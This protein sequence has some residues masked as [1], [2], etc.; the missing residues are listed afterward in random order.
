MT[1]STKYRKGIAAFLFT[2]L[3]AQT[4]LPVTALALTSGPAQ[5]ESSLFQP[6]GVSDMVDMFTGDFNYN[7]PVLDID[8]YPI[9]LS[10]QSG[11]GMDDEASWV[12][13]GWGLNVGA[14]TRQ[15]R[16]IPDDLSGSAYETE[17]YTKPKVTIGGRLTGKIEL[18]GMPK[19]LNVGGSLS[20]GVFSDNYTGIGAELGANAGISYTFAGSGL[21]TAGMGLGIT[22]STASGVDVS[23]SLSLAY[24]QKVSDNTT[25]SPGLSA[26]LG[27]NTRGGLKDLSLG[28]T[29]SGKSKK[30]HSSNTYDVAGATIFYNTDPV[31]PKVQIPYKSYNGSFSFD[32][33]GAGWLIFAGG[34]GTGY[35]TVREVKSQKMRNPAFGFLYAE[36]GKKRAEALMDFVREKENAIIPEIPNLAIPVATP[37]LF[38]YT[39]Q[40]GSGQ[41][42][43]Y[44]GGTGILFDNE[45]ADEDESQSVGFDAGLGGIAHGGVTLYNQNVTNTTS[46]WRDQNNFLPK[47]DFQDALSAD[48]QAEHAFFKQVGEKTQ[49]DEQMVKRLEGTEP[50][51]VDITGKTANNKWRKGSQLVTI[52]GS[53]IKDQKEKKR[54]VISYLTASEAHR[55]GL[56]KIIK[57]YDPITYD[58]NVPFQPT[59]CSPVTNKFLYREY[60]SLLPL[61][62]YRDKS[63]ISELTVTDEAGSRSVYG[64]P[65]YNAYQH[66]YSYALGKKGSQTY[67]QNTAQGDIDN[68]L[69][70]VVSNG[71]KPKQDTE[72]ESDNYLHVDKQPGYA[73]SFLLS[74]ILSPDYVDVTGNG[75]TDDDQGTAIK[76]NYSMLETLYQWRTPFG[77][78][79]VNKATINK[80]MMADPDDDKAS[81]VHGAKELW[82]LHSIETKTKIA[83]FITEDRH[84]A[85][86]VTSWNAT[87][88]GGVKQKALR[89]IRL[90][91]KADLTRPIKVVKLNYEY[92]LCQQLP[93]FNPDAATPQKG[94]LTLK[95]VYFQYGNSP[96]GSNHRYAFSYNN[97]GTSGTGGS[98]DYG[99]LL[100]DRWGTYKSRQANA[101]N[102]YPDLRNDEFPYATQNTADANQWAGIWQLSKIQLPTGGEI[103]VS[104]ESDDYYYVQNKKAMI[105]QKPLAL[106]KQGGDNAATLREA[107]GIK[108]SVSNASAYN[109]NKQKFMDDFLNGS[110][111][112]YT[113]FFVNVGGLDAKDQPNN[114]TYYDFIPCYAKVKEVTAAGS[115]TLNVLFETITEGGETMNPIIH[116]AW[117]RMRLEYPRYSYPGYKNRVKAGDA[118]KALK[119]AITAIINAAKTL[120]ELRRSFYERASD[121]GFANNVN[122]NKSMVR[123]AITTPSK[124]G[125]G[126]RVKKIM[127]SDNWATMSG[128]PGNNSLVRTYGQEYNYTTTVNGQTVSSGVASYEPAVGSD[129]NPLRLPVPYIQNIRGAIN[130]FFN[131]EEPF[132]ESFFPAPSV[133]YSK[134]TVRD[135][136][137]NG[138]AD[139]ARKTGYVVNEFYTARE[140][141]V[142]TKALSNKMNQ[143]GPAGWYSFFG[144]S[145]VH[146]LTFSQGYTIELND[147]HG[148]PK[149]V[150]VYNQTEEEISSIVYHYNTEP[151]NAG[152]M[153]LRNLVNIVNEQGQV[154]ENKIIGREIEVFTDM[155]QQETSSIGETVQI[156]SDLI[157]IFIGVGAWPHF[158]YKVNDDYKLFRS[159]CTMKVIQYY[160]ILDKV[161]KTENGSSITTENVAYDGLTGEVLVTR[162]WNEFKDPVYTVNF[163]AYWMHPGMGGAYRT[164]GTV[165]PSLTTGTDGKINAPYDQ[166]LQAGDELICVE[167]NPARER[168][169]VIETAPDNSS[170]PKTKK[171]VDWSGKVLVSFSGKEAKIIRSGYRNALLPPAASMVCM[172]NPI[173]ENVDPATNKKYIVFSKNET[174]TAWKVL[175]A[176]AVQF[177]D[178]WGM[179]PTCPTCPE[180]YQLNEDG[181]CEIPPIENT[182]E[183]FTLCAGS[184]TPGGTYG[185]EGA[186]I[187]SSPTSG[188]VVR[189]SSFWGGDCSGCG[190]SERVAAMNV[191]AKQSST[192][193]L[194]TMQVCGRTENTPNPDDCANNLCGR[195]LRSGIWLCAADKANPGTNEWIAV[196]FCVD[197]PEAKEYFIGYAGDNKMYIDIDGQQWQH[198][199]GS[200]NASSYENWHVRPY[201]LPQGK[202]R[203]RLTFVNEHGGASVGF[204]IYNKTY[205]ELI[206]PNVVVPDND[207]IFS[208]ARDLLGKK[209]QMFRHM[210]GPNGTPRFTCPSGTGPYDA[211]EGCGKIA[212]DRAVNPYVKGFRGNW[213][214][215]ESKVLQVN[216]T[217]NNIF[218]EKKKGV[219]VRNSGSLTWFKPF[220]YTGSGTTNWTPNSNLKEWVTANT[221]TLYDKYG[222]ELENKDALGRYSAAGFVFKGQLPGAVASNARNREICFESF[223]D[224]N[225][226]NNCTSSSTETC[227]VPVWKPVA[228]GDLVSFVTST[229][230]HSGNYS[231]AL[232]SSGIIFSTIVHNQESKARPYTVIN[233]RGEYTIIP[234]AGLFPV[235]FEPISGKKYIFSAWVK[236]QNQPLMTTPPGITVSVSGASPVTLKRK[237][238]VEKWSLV[239]GVIELSGL[240]EYSPIN[241][242]IIPNGATN[243]DDIRIHPYDGHIKTYAYDDKTLRLMA[244]MDENNFAAFYE[245]D[246]EG[247]LV[248]VKKETERGIMTI[249][250]NRSSQKKGQY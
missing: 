27:Y 17:H 225:F 128:N 42:R 234:M 188:F 161:V 203:I 143:R 245:Y 228:A 141:P 212:I 18:A 62:P 73:S 208:T 189:K 24:N 165:I 40:N 250:E 154:E 163:P 57:Y 1:H 117:Q 53:I 241:L 75:I 35:R 181:I 6:A 137:E 120:D 23:P 184:A 29:F 30:S 37:D 12:G 155:R 217:D 28:I 178:N 67:E 236:E 101:A 10:Y 95:E 219:D 226:N 108:L 231:L 182:S 58:P 205:A 74:G 158:P 144:G 34:G 96:K 115:N 11:A 103:N 127:I 92:L 54:T 215:A 3:V 237:A 214:P 112:L 211:C 172:R 175:T 97:E 135:L 116:A 152:E 14:I 72:G 194:S 157:Y 249:K 238:Y 131:L 5:P 239:E 204:E 167:S 244:E 159:A 76:F 246:N 38:S 64:I 162:T 87:T 173:S 160:G 206:V 220:W 146:E 209:V 130:N 207:I 183:C 121:E 218:N 174:L 22:S 169:W 93:N 52:D 149:A 99:F 43:L 7:L 125:G 195:L 111:Y 113:K 166:F 156:G 26:S 247:A 216:R 16:G 191:N 82:Y 89:E 192:T 80:S 190:G 88:P 41:F 63:H 248:R 145:T 105:M 102:N 81:F 4:L 213:R 199:L 136:D 193:T 100:T 147:M 168:Y 197:I 25:I 139:P 44:R 176:S 150:R 94:K 110:E 227:D 104:Y 233:N 86:G 153:K 164:L 223:E 224:L 70:K 31:Q 124:K 15:L 79:A 240:N 2:I 232:P 68:N 200:A 33:G 123:M 134:V 8:G 78:G 50:I 85:M 142:I 122:L 84:D 170:S 119:A 36:R 151:L 177:D 180:G 201:Y 229:V 148:K 56:D 235:G 202:R 179:R 45:A 83:Y 198:S 69:V 61:N 140:F 91:S 77:N 65:T 90:Y 222:Q 48:P 114:E 106:I 46:K 49:E 126:A 19:G 185:K 129:E 132:G 242:S 171:L 243:I 133:G 51:T 230:A 98:V 187:Y 66:E 60:S 118:G 13:L 186:A 32:I 47:A 138:V 210:D 55:S 221:I 196:E 21:L 39:S 107:E 9:N 59:T 109:G 20:L 71:D